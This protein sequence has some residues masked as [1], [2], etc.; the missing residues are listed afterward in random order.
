MLDPRHYNALGTIRVLHVDD[1]EDQLIIG[2]RFLEKVDQ[3]LKITSTTYPEEAILM[4]QERPF[5]CLVSDYK[6]PQMSGIELAKKIKKTFGIPFIIYTG[7]G[8]EEVAEAAFAVGIDDYVRKEFDPSHYQVLA[9]RI[10]TA[11]EKYLAEEEL[12]KSEDRWRSIVEL[13]PVG[14][15]TLNLLG[16]ITFVN[17]AGE[18]MSGYGKDEMIGKHFSKMGF[19][20]AGDIPIYIKIFSSIIRGNIPPPFEVVFTHKDGTD[21]WVEPHIGLLEVGGKKTGI[22][23]IMRDITEEKQNEARKT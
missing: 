19:F 10:R 7:R 17:T 6:M 8:S 12:K 21:R 5:D 23:A 13:S 14:I 9:K 18:R 15:V 3:S 2:K 1:E 4:L 16:E 11:V 20:R 22:Q